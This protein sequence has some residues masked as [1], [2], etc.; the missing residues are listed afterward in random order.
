MDS[1]TGGFR[2][3]QAAHIRD[4]ALCGTCHTLYTT[5]RGEGG[6]NLG[7]LP[8][9][10]PYLEWLHSDYPKKSTCQSCH[11]PEFPE[12]APITAVLGV[13]RVGAHQH[14]FTGGNFL[15]LRML[16]LYSA[17]LAVTALP[18]ELSAA[19][20]ETVRF[21]QSQA[22]RVEIR[23]AEAS[24]G[25]LHMDVFVQNL[26]GHKLPTAYPSRRAWLHVLVRDRSGAPVFESGALQPD[27]SI[28]GNDNDADKTRYEPHY[29]EISSSE[30]V[31]IYEDILQDQEGHV[32][33]GLLAG[34]SYVKDNRLLPSG[35]QKQTAEKDIA[36]IGDA[37]Q[38]PNFTDGSDLVRYSVALRNAEG[39][40]HIEAELWY[41]PIGFRWAHNLEAYSAAEPKRFVDYFES[42]SASTALVL[43]RAE[44]TR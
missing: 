20:N 44:V 10:M 39:P 5:A 4:S 3:M 1:S 19:A 17:D 9:Q 23:S 18:Q 34:V 8:E 32:T 41:Q 30:Q 7:S 22:A 42:M 21:L 33:T 13:P 36:V 40:F 29:R 14:T 31:Q 43:A 16:N 12:A 24:G 38:D 27:G 26:T 35:F 37:A 6:K 28:A 2:P 11:M 15:L 25:T